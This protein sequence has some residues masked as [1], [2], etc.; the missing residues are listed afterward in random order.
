MVLPV[1]LCVGVFSLLFLFRVNSAII[2]KSLFSLSH[3]HS[4]YMYI[5]YYT[6]S[7]GMK[8][9]L[10]AFEPLISSDDDTR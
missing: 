3:S 5:S 6:S 4:L 7:L 8:N 10:A 9:A 1:A 2:I